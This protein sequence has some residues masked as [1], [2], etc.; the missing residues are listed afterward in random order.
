MVLTVV[1]SLAGITASVVIPMLDTS[2]TDNAFELGVWKTENTPGKNGGWILTP[3]WVRVVFYNDNP[4]ILEADVT[5][6]E[7]VTYRVYE[8]NREET[9]FEFSVT[10][11]MLQVTDKTHWG[12]LEDKYGEPAE[13]LNGIGVRFFEL[14]PLLVEYR[15]RYID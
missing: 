11:Q 3:H 7:N 4:L 6:P 12:N 1:V 5:N 13:V 10:S 9:H 14:T 2:P 15:V 8:Q